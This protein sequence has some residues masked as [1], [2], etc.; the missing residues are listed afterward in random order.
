M[1]KKFNWLNVP[2]PQSNDCFALVP[3]DCGASDRF[4]LTDHTSASFSS[5]PVA[6]DGVE[7]WVSIS[8]HLVQEA[9]Q[10]WRSETKQVSVYQ[11]YQEADGKHYRLSHNEEGS[12]LYNIGADGFVEG[13]VSPQFQSKQTFDELLCHTM[14]AVIEA[15]RAPK[16]PPIPGA[17]VAVLNK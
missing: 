3:E 4:M 7:S 10:S 9:D 14:V 5:L 1:E 12:Y 17:A 13:L 16:V 8:A 15:R 6:V 2:R 11:E